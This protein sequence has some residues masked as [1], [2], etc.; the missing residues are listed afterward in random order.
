MLR[1]PVIKRKH[2]DRLVSMP[3][4]RIQ[5]NGASS[6]LFGSLPVLIE[7]MSHSSQMLW[8]VQ[9]LANVVQRANVRM[10]EL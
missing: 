5:F 10:I 7:Q 1:K 8:S 2:R 3:R 9:P 6:G 4:A